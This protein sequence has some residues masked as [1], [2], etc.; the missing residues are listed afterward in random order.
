MDA[1]YEKRLLDLVERALELPETERSA[2]LETACNDVALREEAAQCLAGRTDWLTRPRD[3]A[4]QSMPER[5]GPYRILEVIGSGG[6]GQVYRAEREDGA[7][8]KIVAIKAIKP[9]MDAAHIIQRFL[10]ER[11]IL[12]N[13][14][15][16]HIAKLLDGGTHQERPYFVMEHVPGQPID[17]YCD[18]NGLTL[19]E[20]LSLFEKVCRAVQFAHQNF[21]VHRDLKPANILVADDGEPKLLDF[22]I[23]K[24][25]ENEAGDEATGTAWRAMTP[26]WAS[27]E[28]K[29]GQPVTAAS[30][31]YALGL[32]LCR[33][34]AGATPFETGLATA[35]APAPHAE[36]LR[37]SQIARGLREQNDAIRVE[38]LCRARRTQPARLI[39][40]LA[41]D[42]DSIALKALRF[43][44]GARYP[45]VSQLAEDAARWLSGRPV[46]ARK[47]ALRYRAGKF[48][49]R[50]RTGLLAAASLLTA[51]VALP[52]GFGW[53]QRL[54]RQETERALQRAQF[55]TE[56]LVQLF[57]TADP[58]RA[59]TDLSAQALLEKASEQLASKPPN[60]PRLRAELL[61]VM[62]RVHFNLGRLDPAKA[63]LEEAL[64]L[65]E[66]TGRPGS[67]D[68][69][70]TAYALANLWFDSGEF[71]RADALLKRVLAARETTG[72]AAEPDTARLLNGL[73]LN[74]KA[75]SRLDEAETL[76][77]QAL[78]MAEDDVAPDE[79]L[80]AEIHD[81]LGVILHAA[82]KYERSETHLRQAVAYYE[83]VYRQIHP[84][85]ANGWHNLGLTLQERG[86][87]AEAETA[88][89]RAL[90]IFEAVFGPDHPAV[91]DALGNLGS[92]YKHQRRFSEALPRLER[93]AGIVE[94][95]R[96]G[97]APGL[98][99]IFS[100]LAQVCHHLGQLD[101][102][103][104]LYRRTLAIRRQTY[105][106]AHPETAITLNDLAVLEKERGRYDEAEALY[107]QALEIYRHTVGLDHPHAAAAF[108]HLGEIEIAR[109][110]PSEAEALLRQSLE[111][112]E[113]KLGPDHHFAAHSL[114]TLAT[115]YREQGRMPE[116]L[117]CIE[118]T[119]AIRRNTL[120]AGHPSI[121]AALE[122]KTA[123]E[124][125][126][127]GLSERP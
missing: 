15:H 2:F 31:V 65:R 71:E 127:R 43:D 117:A 9:G 126:T 28:Q 41:G 66:T 89:Q 61:T 25:L 18:D 53:A 4:P 45:S 76:A 96:G 108:Y 120:P 118:R 111:I 40:E 7:Y 69:A 54:E 16:P 12:A 59:Q 42:L 20:R 67:E 29:R 93:A 88:S 91:A 47:G 34:L 95:A 98:G 44:P 3:D 78:A 109:G 115:L 56:F 121:A 35:K 22:G 99:P 27:P 92:L 77:R 70:Q 101:R 1:I 21:V 87:F 57:D 8:S 110:R 48:V 23:A 75:M 30:D 84:L 79:R 50:H 64:A 36:P 119:L 11:Q 123:L 97:D 90:D 81:N 100:N 125:E 46:L 32:L 86:K 39:R 38:E 14:N 80:L 62:G 82:A 103:E 107:R 51:M 73:A 83:R 124:N 19:R 17:R 24:L 37:P 74:H 112:V 104:S 113:T 6:M 33:L 68:Y 72:P 114:A 5:I 49:R 10:R 63:M 102:A 26:E 52:L 55:V 116:A 85:T 106:E 60:D 13:L 58:Y 122:I 94:R 105:G